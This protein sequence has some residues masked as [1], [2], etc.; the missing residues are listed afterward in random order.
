MKFLMQSQALCVAFAAIC[1]NCTAISPFSVDFQ[2][3]AQTLCGGI[4]F[5]V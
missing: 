1:T 5:G 3:S 2:H 4:L